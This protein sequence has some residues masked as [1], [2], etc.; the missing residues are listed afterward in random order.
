[1]YEGNTK[2]EI[3]HQFDWVLNT[4]WILNCLYIGLVNRISSERKVKRTLGTSNRWPHIFPQMCFQGCLG[5]ILRTSW[6]HPESVPPGRILDVRLGRSLDVISRCPQVVSL[7][8]P[9]DGQIGSLGDV[10]GT[11]EGDAQGPLFAGWV[12]IAL[13]AT[14]ICTPVG[15]ASASVSFSCCF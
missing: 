7:G 5:D 11:F 1:M 13:F 12:S 15:T 10:L 6:G 4:P 14:V 8:R 3:L 9:W 2:P